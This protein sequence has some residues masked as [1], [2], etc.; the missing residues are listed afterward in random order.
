MLSVGDR[1]LFA[2]LMVVPMALVTVAVE[3]LAQRL[4][5]ETDEITVIRVEPFEFPDDTWVSRSRA[6]PTP[7]RWR[8]GLS[9][10]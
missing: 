5:V 4:E 8:L 10:G 7:R 9:S 2:M 3:E 6:N 1:L